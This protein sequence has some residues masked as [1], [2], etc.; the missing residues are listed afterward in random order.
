MHELARWS[1]RH[2]WTVI[3]LWLVALVG[4]QALAAAFGS[5][6]SAQHEPAHTDSARVQALL[7]AAVPGHAGDTDRIVYA[8][9][10]GSLD[11]PQVRHRIDESVAAVARL[12]HVASVVSPRSPQGVGQVSSNGRIA[13]ATVQF[14][15]LADQLPVSVTQQVIAVARAEAGGGLQ[16]EMGGEAVSAAA[17]PSVG[18]I[19]LGILAAG[20]ILLLAFGSLV[21]MGLPLATAVVSLGTGLG[22]VGALS[23]VLSMADFTPELAS[24]VG[25]GV[26][27]DYAMFIVSRHR[28]G[29][30]AGHSVEE[31]A[32]NAVNT[33]GRAVLFAGTT[34][35]IALLGMFALGLQ[36]FDGVGVG[37]SVVV[38]VTVLAALTLQPA[39]L[40]IFG[41]R[42][43]SRRQRRSIGRSEAEGSGSA[44]WDAW[45]MRLR[46]NPR[47]LATAGFLALV[48]LAIPVLSLRLGFSDAGNLPTSSTGRRAYDLLAEGFGPGFNGPLTLVTPGTSP[49]DR[50]DFAATLRQVGT[51]PGVAQ[52]SKPVP[53]GTGAHALL[54]AQVVPTTAP[55]SAATGTLLHHLRDD[56]IPNA[57]AGT[58]LDVRVGGVVAVDEDF[59][60]VISRHLLLFIGLVIGLSFL[61]LAVVFRSLVVPLLAALMNLLSVAASFGVVTAVFEKGWLMQAI[62]VRETAPIEPFIP[63][64]VF[65][66]LFGLSMDYEV[67]IVARMHEIW[68]R[69]RSNDI[70]VTRGLAETGRTVTAAA[71]IMVFVFG[72]FMLGDDRVIKLF[73]LGLATA[74]LIDALIIRT[75]VLPATMLM[76]GRLNWAMPSALDRALPRLHVEGSGVNVEDVGLGAGAAAHR[77]GRGCP[78]SPQSTS[79]PSGNAARPGGA[80]AA[81]H[82]QE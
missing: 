3:A 56:V 6:Y 22:I 19:G 82:A 76:L 18:G 54:S 36:V 81:V 30:L 47:T 77:P 66:V 68:V 46:R 20:V 1:F 29:L 24:L 80:A 33:S 73:G 51:T 4:F 35:C 45:A 10:S 11:S 17:A 75:L 72:A 13:Y 41:K 67:F 7:E 5:D 60:H 16:I 74:V 31:S 25:L 9:R 61:L 70:A 62:G 39:L 2:R 43:L 64:I 15:D 37:V 50:E 48:V 52:V 38:L 53:L 26:G 78:A 65:A 27:V 49:Q 55:Q 44:T 12:P 79:S 14:D 40:S 69:T 21:A 57:S 59:S 63:V 28:S 42:V 23:N 8:V 32:V 71:A 34:V 58:R